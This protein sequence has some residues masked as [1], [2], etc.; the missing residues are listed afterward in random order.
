MYQ[1][2]DD[3]ELIHV[4][5]SVTFFT[6]PGKANRKITTWIFC[7][8]EYPDSFSHRGMIVNFACTGKKN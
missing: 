1:C 8:G 4:V 2:A 6:L 5:F 3:V 7:F